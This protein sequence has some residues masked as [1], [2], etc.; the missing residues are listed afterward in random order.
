M[1][2]HFGYYKPENTQGGHLSRYSE[3][4][5]VPKNVD[6]L[7]VFGSYIRGIL[8]KKRVPHGQI[9][10]R[11]QDIILHTMTSPFFD[12]VAD[13]VAEGR[14]SPANFRMYLGAVVSN[15]VINKFKKNIK[16]GNFDT[17]LT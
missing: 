13:R 11:F 8:V 14:M 3:L 7:M 1:E 10:D 6:E 4:N 9:D 17:L 16:N 15:I 12:R 2:A 5:L